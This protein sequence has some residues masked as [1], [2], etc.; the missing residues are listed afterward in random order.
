MFVIKGGN[1]T[2]GVD[3]EE[4][5]KDGSAW[6]EALLSREYPF[7]KMFLPTIPGGTG[8]EAV[9]AIDDVKWSGAARC[10]RLGAVLSRAGTFFGEADENAFV[11][12]VG[13]SLFFVMVCVRQCIVVV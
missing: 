1:H 7:G 8:N 12:V 9:V 2:G 13:V 4:I 5:R 11:V 10:I 6:Q 3:F